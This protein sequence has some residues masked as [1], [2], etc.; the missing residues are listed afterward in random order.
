MGMT[1][2]RFTLLGGVTALRDDFPG[3]AAM[4][5]ECFTRST[6]PDAEFAKVQQLAIGAIARRA[7]DPHQQISELFS[8][9]LPADSPYHIIQG[10]KAETVGKLTAKDL[11]EYHAKYFTPN[12]MLVTIFGD[13]DL[14]KAAATA[15]QLFGGL[16]PSARFRAH[17]VRPQQRDCE[18]HRPSSDHRQADRDGAVWLSHAKHPAKGRTLRR[19]T[20]LGAVMAGYRYPGGWLHNELRGEG[21]VYFVHAYPVTG[22]VPGYFDIIAQTRPDKLNEVVGRIEKNVER[23]KKGE[24]GKDEFRTAV[25]RVMALHAQENTTIAE[26]AQQAALDEL[27]GLGHDYHKSFDTRIQAVKLEDLA[28]SRE[29]V[30]RQPRVGHVVAG[31]ERIGGHVAPDR[32]RTPFCERLER[33]TDLPYRHGIPVRQH[34]CHLAGHP[35]HAA[36]GLCRSV[37]QAAVGDGARTDHARRGGRT[38][39]ALGRSDPRRRR[40]PDSARSRQHGTSPSGPTSCCSSWRPSIRCGFCWFA[41]RKSARQSSNA[42]NAGASVPCRKRPRKCDG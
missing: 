11:R 32:R 25:E 2:G 15:E 35:C 8:D 13:I 28:E 20:V 39:A 29:E 27:Y 19:V 23:A 21:L 10:G 3:A 7:N 12:N 31:K 41:T 14:D 1:A 34:D 24:I 9:S 6:F 17:L 40:D 30:L 16:K 18:D 22:P 36:Y 38:V 42:V 33:E 37:G 5:T 4:F 26:Q